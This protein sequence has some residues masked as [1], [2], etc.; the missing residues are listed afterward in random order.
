MLTA[1]EHA[2]FEKFKGLFE[3]GLDPQTSD[4]MEAFFTLTKP[5]CCNNANELMLAAHSGQR[6]SASAISLFK[7]Y[8]LTNANGVIPDTVKSALKKA[9]AFGYLIMHDLS[10]PRLEPEDFSHLDYH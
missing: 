4:A 9:V 5:G 7:E 6:V 2:R 8:G 10:A 3:G 1:V